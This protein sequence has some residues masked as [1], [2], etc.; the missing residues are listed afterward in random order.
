MPAG[1]KKPGG[2]DL[3]CPAGEARRPAVAQ[4]EARKE[5]EPC[6]ALASE[7]S[8]LWAAYRKAVRRQRCRAYKYIAVPKK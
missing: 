1:D 6:P 5:Q 3:F 8:R 4:Q 7:S 2:G